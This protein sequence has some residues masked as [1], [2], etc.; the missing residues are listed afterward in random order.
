MWSL[1]WLLYGAGHLAYLLG[2]RMHI[3]GMYAP[4]NWLMLRSCDICER[5]GFS[6][7]WDCK[8]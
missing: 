3:P 1:A 2:D 7:P 5:F 4:Y 6:S 8:D